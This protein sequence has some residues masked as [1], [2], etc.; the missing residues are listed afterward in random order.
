[1]AS[2]ARMVEVLAEKFSREITMLDRGLAVVAPLQAV[3]LVA[4]AA[5]VVVVVVVPCCS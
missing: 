4:L 3:E 5:A 2:R 1:M